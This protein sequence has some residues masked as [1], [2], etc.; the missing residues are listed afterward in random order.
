[1]Y[2]AL[3]PRARFRLRNVSSRTVVVGKLP[4]SA[5]SIF[6][7]GQMEEWAGRTLAW[8]LANG[9]REEKHR[10]VR[11]RTPAHPRPR[12]TLHFLSHQLAHPRTFVSP[13][14]GHA[15]WLGGCFAL[16]AAAVSLSQ[17]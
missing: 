8:T 7:D 3:L 2:Y 16:S 15:R 17:I 4:F 10:R 5:E 13:A 12:R 6:F 1:M 14:A 11:T 9:E